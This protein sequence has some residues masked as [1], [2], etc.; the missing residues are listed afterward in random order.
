MV[1]YMSRRFQSDVFLTLET[2][3]ARLKIGKSYAIVLTT[4]FETKKAQEKA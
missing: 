2:Y 3:G 4:I 1:K